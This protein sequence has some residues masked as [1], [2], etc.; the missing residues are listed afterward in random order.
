MSP[1]LLQRAEPIYC[2]AL[3]REP[4]TRAAFVAN[5]CG[6]DQ[7]LREEVES[8]LAEADRC[9][10]FLS[11]AVFASALRSAVEPAPLQPS[12]QPDPGSRRPMFVWFAIAVGIAMLVFFIC[13][14]CVTYRNIGAKDFGWESLYSRAGWT[15]ARIYAGGPADGKL[16]A[17]DRFQAFNGDVRAA[18]VG[19]DSFRQFLKPGAVYSVGVSRRGVPHEYQLRVQPWPG[20]GA[21]WAASY[22]IL[23]IVNFSTGLAMALLKPRDRLAQLGFA[24]LTLAALRNLASPLS[25]HPGT[26]PD[27]EFMLNQVAALSFPG[28]LAVGYHFIYRMSAESAK[29]FAWLAIKRILYG[30]SAVLALSQLAYLL[31]TLSG[32]KVLINFAWRYFWV[33]ELNVVFLK[34]SW[35]AALTVAFGAICALIIWGY[36][37]SNDINYRRRIRW[38]VAGCTFGIAPVMILNLVGWVLASTGH[39]G[40]LLSATWSN[41]RWIA[42]QFMVALPA[43]LMY[44]VL[45]HRLFDIR[46]VVRRGLRYMLA[47]RVLQAILILPFLGL[48]LPIVTHPNESLIQ[49]L[50]R[51]SSVVNVALLAMVGLILRYRRQMREWLDR[52][53]FREAYQQEVVL[54]RLMARI[55]ELD[56]VE[57]VSRIVCNELDAALHPKWLYLAEWRGE[58]ADLAFV[59]ASTPGALRI[60]APAREDLLGLLK[61]CQQPRECVLVP[62]GEHGR[63]ANGSDSVLVIPVSTRSWN[64]GGALLL[65]ERKSEEPYTDTDRNMLDAIADAMAMAFE[66]LDLKKKVDEELREKHEVLG[67]LDRDHINLLKECPTCGACYDR[68]DETCRDDCSRLT[69]SLPVERTIAQRY[70]LERRIGQG[71]M[72]VVFEG[73]DLNLSRTVAVKVTTGRLFGDQSALRR[74]DREARI[75]AQ[76]RHPNIVALHDFGRLGADGAYLVMERVAGTSWRA[77]LQRLGKVPPTTL[78]IWLDQLLGGLHAAHEGGVVHR[79]LKPEN[80]IIEPCKDGGCLLKILDFGVAKAKLE[81]S[82]GKNLT[83]TGIVMGTVAYMSPEQLRGEPADCRSDIFSVGVMAVEAI[84]GRLPRRAADGTITMTM[85]SSMLGVE[86]GQAN[87]E[88][89]PLLTRCLADDPNKRP[90]SVTEIREK[91]VSAMWHTT[92]IQ[93]A[94]LLKS[95]KQL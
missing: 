63:D 73:T 68:V 18:R 81:A 43:A 21:F 88:L 86:Q 90:S 57:E 50:R 36:W 74:F 48:I 19:P 26:P 17:G 40:W 35:E 47:R 85:L 79:D 44:G 51:S 56:S 84:S 42:D 2:E 60:A 8:L 92:E 61:A 1:S 59:R 4:S 71:G 6:D 87:V 27:M 24:T 58:P 25:M 95:Q 76:L 52:R 45:K 31:A 30:V 82:G 49:L 67:R 65:G 38:F 77:E 16:Q 78:A 41:L 53:F 37:H 91:L 32:P 5:A 14:G 55:K 28:A 39:R 34:T 10:G 46:V 70:R 33:A 3:S 69:L 15:A 9:T 80:A 22:F 11:S 62:G 83:E 13:A 75:L 29:E 64:Q 20:L 12:T 93:D 89:H 66:N 7:E 94:V 54:R 23:G 72:G